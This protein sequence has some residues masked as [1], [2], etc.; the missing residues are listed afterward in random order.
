MADKAR[1]PHCNEIRTFLE[2]R[3]EITATI[4]HKENN[5]L[6]FIKCEGCN[7]TISIRDPYLEQEK[8]RITER[9]QELQQ[10]IDH[11]EERIQGLTPSN[12]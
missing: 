11:L 1:C 6:F 10:M 5:N 12:S 7:T 8:E 9:Y 2:C 3:I 4:Q